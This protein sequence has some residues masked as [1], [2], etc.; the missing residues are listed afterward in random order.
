[1]GSI[2][3]RVPLLLVLAPEVVVNSEEELINLIND[4]IKELII[5]GQVSVGGGN[6]VPTES[7]AVELTTGQYSI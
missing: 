5:G 3:V 2:G 1:M 6:S 7:F 4:H